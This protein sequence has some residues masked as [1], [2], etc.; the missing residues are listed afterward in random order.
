MY[1]LLLQAE[2]RSKAK[3]L[4]KSVK[5]Y[6]VGQ[7]FQVVY[8]LTNI[9]YQLFPGGTFSV[10]IKWPNGQIEVTP[11]TIPQLAPNE[12]RSAEPKSEWGVLSRGFALFFVTSAVD[13]YGKDIIFYSDPKNTISG[14]VSFYSVLG[15][16]PEELY[17][18]WAM[19]AAV[20]ALFILV[21]EKLYE[22]IRSIISLVN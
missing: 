6:V 19:I 20:V 11:Y 18:Y 4:R 21:G 3:I 12:T 5:D 7:N 2:S 17:Q 16:D 15:K 10:E 1:K 8:K 9:G 22:I 14:L 13:N